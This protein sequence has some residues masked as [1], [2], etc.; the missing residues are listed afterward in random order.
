MTTGICEILIISKKSALYEAHALLNH[1]DRSL[2]DINPRWLRNRPSIEIK[3]GKEVFKEDFNFPE[4][5]NNIDVF[6]GA[7]S[8]L[9]LNN[10]LFGASCEGRVRVLENCKTGELI[11]VAEDPEDRGGL[12]ATLR[13]R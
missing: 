6:S 2:A 10:C 8:L 11:K 13:Q 5:R 1:S 7:S 9:N 12:K 4:I 3:R